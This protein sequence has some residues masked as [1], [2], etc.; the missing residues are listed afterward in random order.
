MQLKRL[1]CCIIGRVVAVPDHDIG[2]Q[3]LKIPHIGWNALAPCAPEGW[4]HRLLKD[5]WD[6][7]AMYFVHSFMAIPDDPG[8]RLADC[9]Y[10]GHAIS[11]IVG[12]ENVFGCQFHPEKSGEAGLRLIKA[13]CAL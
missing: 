5:N 10:G 7:D 11:A 2:G 12:R 3:P 13:F 1:C 6:G 9:H 8:S 4:Q